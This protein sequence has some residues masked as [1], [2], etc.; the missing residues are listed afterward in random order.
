MIPLLYPLVLQGTALL[1]ALPAPAARHWDGGRQGPPVPGLGPARG[2]RWHSWFVDP[3]KHENMKCV[4]IY[5]YVCVAYT[6]IYNY[7][8]IYT[9]V[10]VHMYTYIYI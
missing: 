10:Y 2:W 1:E 8:Y 6:Y 9:Y 7:T 5:I 4:E 3:S